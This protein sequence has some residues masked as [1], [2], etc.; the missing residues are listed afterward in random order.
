MAT[1]LGQ[2]LTDT[3]PSSR[4][5]PTPWRLDD[6]LAQFASQLPAADDCEFR[7]RLA[8]LTN[9][10]LIIL[11]QVARGYQNK[12]IAWEC[13]IT[14]AT[15]KAHVSEALRRLGMNSRTGAAVS[16]ALLVERVWRTNAQ[17]DQPRGGA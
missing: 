5:D 4:H 11:S 13:N 16:F 2:E 7:T 3:R 14:E 6:R 15:V 12:R 9:M 8:S 1:A 17:E 10:Q